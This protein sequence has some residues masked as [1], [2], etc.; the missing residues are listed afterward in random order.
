M[1]RQTRQRQSG[2]TIMELLMSLIVIVVGMMVIFRVLSSSVQGGQQSSRVAQAQQRAEAII[3]AIRLAPSAA[4]TCLTTTA[5]A[6]W[7]GANCEQT[8]LA[9]QTAYAAGT[10]KQSTCVFT[11]DSFLYVPGPT[12]PVNTPDQ[13]AD[14]QGQK[15]FFVANKPAPPP[16]QPATY[17]T[18]Y[19]RLVDAALRTAEITITIGWNDDNTPTVTGTGN[20]IPY[21]NH[22]ITLI[23]GVAQ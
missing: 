21:P 7:G 5:P 19:V 12:T 6:A 1:Y 20:G 23:T 18:T 10:A 16:T 8:C 3:E 13:R 14:R 4:I 22:S 2:V 9:A 17:G 15:Y 11:P